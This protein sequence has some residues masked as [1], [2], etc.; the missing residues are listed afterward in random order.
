MKKLLTI[1]MSLS[2]LFAF[3]ACGDGASE[4]P[5]GAGASLVFTIVEGE[6]NEYS[7]TPETD[8]LG[9]IYAIP[10]GTYNVT[11]LEDSTAKQGNVL[12]KSD[13]I[14]VNSSGYNENET[15]FMTGTLTPGGDSATITV[16][17]NQHIIITLNSV[18][19]FNKID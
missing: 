6:Q 11:M 5:G 12:V 19:E 9:Y 15:I 17:D 7:R 2:L 4:E 3:V 18:M 16:E 13:E 14:Y 8:I 1:I 10:T